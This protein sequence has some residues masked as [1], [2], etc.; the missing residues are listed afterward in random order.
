VSVGD[1][2]FVLYSI[3]PDEEKGWATLVSDAPSAGASGDLLIWP[4][5]ISLTRQRLMETGTLK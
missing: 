4:P 3:G 2:Q 1:D 5:V